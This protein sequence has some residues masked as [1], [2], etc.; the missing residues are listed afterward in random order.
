M[1]TTKPLESVDYLAGE[2][3][4]LASMRGE[5]ANDKARTLQTAALISV[6][7]S[8]ERIADKM[9]EYATLEAAHLFDPFDAAARTF[10]AETALVSLVED[11][12]LEETAPVTREEPTEVAKPKKAK[13]K[14]AKK[15]KAKKAATSEPEP[16][17]EP[18]K[19]KPAKKAARPSLKERLAEATVVASAAAADAEDWEDPEDDTPE[20]DELE[21]TTRR[22]SDDDFGDTGDPDPSSNFTV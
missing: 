1:T 19:A 8:L 21:A 11:G 2:L 13:A 12:L 6:A 3:P 14:K 22:G 4:V 20:A 9:P 18:V 16:A 7:R 5:A 17:V 10:D 15:A